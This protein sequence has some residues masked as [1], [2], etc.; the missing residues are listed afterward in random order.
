MLRNFRLPALSVAGICA[1]LAPA[2]HAQQVAPRGG[3]PYYA[4]RDA[5]K[6]APKNPTTPVFHMSKDY[7]HSVPNRCPECTWLRRN[8]EL[9]SLFSPT[10]PATPQVWAG[11]W[12]AYMERL[13][14]YIIQGQDMSLSNKE[15]WHTQVN[16]KTRW[17]NVPWMAYDP[18]AGRE[19]VHGTTNERTAHLKDITEHEPHTDD[20][21]AHL[22]KAPSPACLA[23][24]K[25]GFESWSVGYYNEYGGQALGRAVPATGVPAMSTYMGSPVPAGLPFPTGTMVIKVLTS[26][27]PVECAPFLAGSPAWE[28][29]RHVLTEDK[30]YQCE[31]A[32]QISHVVQFD[33]AVVDPRSPTRW[34]YGTFVYDNTQT[35]HYPGVPEDSFWAH[36]IPLGLQWGSDP[37]TF[38]AV[39]KEASLP[40]QQSV[41]NP[42]VKTYQHWGCQNRLA[43]PVDNPQSS[44]TSC[45]M[46][47][48]AAPP[49]AQTEMGQNAPSSF[50]FSGL[51]E[52]FSQ[53]NTNYFQNQSMPQGY[54]GGLFPQA[55]SMD[56]SLQLA[57][58]FTQYGEF[59]TRHRPVACTN[60]NQG[61]P[62]DL[63]TVAP[64]KKLVE[65]NPR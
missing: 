49:G 2:M 48:Y 32:V 50:G 61:P 58:A 9:D 22:A 51:C 64:G 24:N 20:F 43:G 38:P 33:V 54:P 14:E 34:V 21:L 45:H 19:Y 65:V 29:D 12:N 6:P 44:C 37:W 18:T 10:F 26:S 62:V 42:N 25:W 4:F 59:N 15:G 31:R 1:L 11:A 23:A 36:M 41:L 28:I 39:P 7:P 35:N 30:G 17:F 52:A 46:S 53:E 8:K 55:I 63:M 60:P 40:I 27:V 16:G 57:V 5:V 47:A 3:A 13:F 56:T